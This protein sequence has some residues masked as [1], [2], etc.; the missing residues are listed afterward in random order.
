MHSGDEMRARG[1]SHALHR[2]PSQ[3]RRQARTRMHDI[4][5]LIREQLFQRRQVAQG[6]QRL[7]ADVQGEVLGTRLQQ[8]RQQAATCGNHQRAMAGTYQ[9]FGDFQGRTLHPAGFQRGQQ[10]H[11]GKSTHRHAARAGD[12]Q[13]ARTKC[14]PQY[15][16]CTSPLGAS[17]MAR[18]TRGCEFHNA[19]DGNGQLNGRSPRCTV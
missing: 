18:Y 10:L 9:R 2:L 14:E 11:Y 7:A 16:H 17:S 5:L 15:G 19:I 12:V 8:G 13:S 6:Q 1:A 4:Y 3:P